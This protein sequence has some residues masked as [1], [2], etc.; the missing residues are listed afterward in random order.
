MMSL[1]ICDYCVQV[2]EPYQQIQKVRQSI[3][4]LANESTRL[5]VYYQQSRPVVY[6]N[7]NVLVLGWYFNLSQI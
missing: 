2:K 1:I 3:N 7:T 6:N 4:Q 5:T